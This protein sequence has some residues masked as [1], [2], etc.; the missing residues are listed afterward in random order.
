MYTTTSPAIR[1]ERS[2]WSLF[3]SEW[4]VSYNSCTTANDNTAHDLHQP[5]VSGGSALCTGVCAQ[6]CFWVDC[7]LFGASCRESRFSRRCFASRVEKP[8]ADAPE[9]ALT[10]VKREKQQICLQKNSPPDLLFIQDV[11]Q[12]FFKINLLPHW[13]PSVFL[14]PSDYFNWCVNASKSV[15]PACD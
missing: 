12:Y 11:S 6:V 13:S 5:A 9:A 3:P 4:S 2:L 10:A 7:L 14:L 1:V 8:N 15:Q